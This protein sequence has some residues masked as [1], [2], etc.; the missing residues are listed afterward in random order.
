M[1]Y[2]RIFGRWTRTVI[3]SGA[4]VAQAGCIGAL[5]DPASKCGNAQTAAAFATLPDTG[6]AAST[7]VQV[8][9]AQFDPFIIG[10][11]SDIS[12]QHLWPSTRGPNPEA[13]PR[14]RLVRDDGRVLLDTLAT[15]RLPNDGDPNR[16]TWIVVQRTQS[17]DRRNAVFNAMRD[18]T[19][20]LEL[21]SRNAAADGT[22]V[23][24]RTTSASVSPIATC[25]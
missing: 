21:W 23:R 20:W 16:L 9:L 12:V 8:V 11:L 14:V 24:L 2:L 19:L 1:S 15:R 25:V 4:I 10:E 7:E 5:T 22:R 17:A 6:I 13:D 18:Q 3:G